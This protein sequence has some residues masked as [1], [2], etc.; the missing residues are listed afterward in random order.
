MPVPEMGRERFSQ[1]SHE[2]T[3]GFVSMT[4]YNSPNSVANGSDS[5]IVS[6]RDRD[7]ERARSSEIA[8]TTIRSPGE[9][10]RSNSRKRR[11]TR[12][13]ATRLP[14]SRRMMTSLS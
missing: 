14:R 9:I 3:I 1:H 2:G 4:R 8:R 11:I 5:L 6:Q 10:Q 13:V 7:R 12:C